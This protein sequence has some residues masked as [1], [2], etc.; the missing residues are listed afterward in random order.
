[1]SA[2]SS[3]VPFTKPWLSSADQ[4][5]LLQQR[6]LQITDIAAAELFLGHV[7]YYRFSGYC[8]AFE[9]TRH[10]FVAGATFDQV[11][12][13]YQ[14]DLALRDLITEALE[15]IEVDLRT[16]IAQT[17]GRQHG[18]FGHT[19]PTNFYS[20]AGHLAWLTRIRE[21]AQRSSELFVTHCART[22]AE[23]P[24][25]PVWMVTEVMS[26][27]ALSK[28]FHQMKK[29]DQAAVA[30]RYGLQAQTL[31]SWMHHLVYVR[32]LC[33]HHSRLW[34]RSWAIKPQLPAGK[35]W[36]AP[37][38]RGNARLYSTLLLIS[39]LMKCTVPVDGFRKAW[40]R[41]VESHLSNMPSVP[42][43]MNVMGFC[44]DWER[45]P[46]WT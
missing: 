29:K 36:Q 32:N 16:A 42:Q 19:D 12:A 4:V 13:A 37:R 46:A 3:K 20:A 18:A 7:N 31:V 43:A 26:F 44:A 33:A 11:L 40:S 23:F 28:M 6:G 45:H 1:M 34:D 17:F 25:L 22:Y 41:R 24:D 10:S 27:G 15:V 35:D 5:R 38:V 2:G 9:S 30:G 14:F 21:E 8:L 39:Q